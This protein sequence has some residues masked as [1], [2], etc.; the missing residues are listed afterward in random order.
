MNSFTM[1]GFRYTGDIEELEIRH[2][3]KHWRA[4]LDGHIELYGSS[5]GPFREDIQKEV[6][7]RGL[8]VTEHP[9]GKGLFDGLARLGRSYNEMLEARKGY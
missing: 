6:D 1:Y 2:D 5:C 7:R 3:G 9:G 4:F 8:G